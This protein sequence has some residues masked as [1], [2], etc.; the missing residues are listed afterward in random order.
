MNSTAELAEMQDLY[1]K[2]TF[3]ESMVENLSLDWPIRYLSNPVGAA[4]Y[5]VHLGTYSHAITK[6][7]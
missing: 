7:I 3:V 2:H 4:M 1:V 6:N 5:A